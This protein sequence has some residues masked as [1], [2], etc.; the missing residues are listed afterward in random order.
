MA[1]RLQKYLARC[2]L[3]SRRA[4]EQWI[5]DGRVKVNGEVVAA[6]GVTIDPSRDRVE[7]DGRRIS[8]PA[9]CSVVLHKPVGVLSAAKDA[10]GR[11]TVVD[12]VPADVRL[13][14][15]GRLDLASEGLILLTNDGDLAMRLTHP[16]HSV[17]KE[18]RVLV[19]GRPDRVA[20]DRL[21]RGVPLD[22]VMTAPA[23]VDL[24][25]PTSGGAWIRIVLREGR[26]R[27]VRRMAGVVRLGVERLIRVRIGPVRLGNLAPGQWRRLTPDEVERLREAGR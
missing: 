20:L 12:L 4:A 25:R 17:E 15:V 23:D 27:Q 2:G 13:F 26:S 22:G 24:L 10:R 18:Y 21:R 9:A 8:T 7:V 16:R 6:P 14:P 5:G 11:V 19:V 3:A 1:E